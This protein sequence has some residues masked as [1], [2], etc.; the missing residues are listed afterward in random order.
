MLDDIIWNNIQQNETKL[1]DIRHGLIWS[2]T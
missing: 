1:N 2:D